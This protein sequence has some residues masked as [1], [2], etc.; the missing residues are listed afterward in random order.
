MNEFNDEDS[1]VLAIYE[2]LDV[3]NDESLKVKDPNP[4]FIVLSDS[5]RSREGFVDSDEGPK[6]LIKKM[7]W[8]TPT[9]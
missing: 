1:P 4:K 6:V 5:S 2:N 3:P 9:I 7:K 8:R